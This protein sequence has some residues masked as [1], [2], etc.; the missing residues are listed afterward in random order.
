MTLNV[1]SMR[2]LVAP[3]T[4]QHDLYGTYVALLV[5]ADVEPYQIRYHINKI[6]K[7]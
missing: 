6:I 3:R 1:T 4:M 5:I 7:N 2:V